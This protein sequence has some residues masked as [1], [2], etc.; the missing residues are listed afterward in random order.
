MFYRVVSKEVLVKK[1][2][3]ANT[4]FMDLLFVYKLTICIKKVISGTDLQ[5]TKR[6]WLHGLSVVIKGTLEILSCGGG[7]CRTS[8][9]VL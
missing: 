5:H 3:V 7:C 6:V 8:N 4:L 1:S 9:S 2:F